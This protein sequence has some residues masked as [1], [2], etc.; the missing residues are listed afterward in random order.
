MDMIKLK[1]G[2]GL[3]CR[4]EDGSGYLAEDG[5]MVSLNSYYRRRLADGDAVEVKDEPAK[6]AKAK[7]A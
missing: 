1:P 4:L 5:Q 3:L 2:P 7:E 6:P